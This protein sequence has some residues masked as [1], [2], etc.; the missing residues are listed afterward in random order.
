MLPN[1]NPRQMQ[2]MMKKMGIK[3]V[4]VEAQEVIIKKAN[5]IIR[6][7]N[8]SIQKINMMGNESFQITGNVSEESLETEVEI[9]DE[10]IETVA[11]TANVSKEEAKAA[12]EK[13]GDI[14]GA[15]LELQDA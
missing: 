13:T 14:A 4:D 8:P 12:L 3:Q 2:A 15:I 10:D 11:T 1:M 5:S 7:T 9:T 6:I